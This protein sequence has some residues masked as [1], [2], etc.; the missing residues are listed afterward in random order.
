MRNLPDVQSFL[1]PVNTKLVTN[2]LH[3]VAKPMDLHTIQINIKQKKYK[4]RS[5]F[6]VDINQ[7][8]ENSRL[9]YGPN[10]F[11]SK[12]A[13]KLLEFCCN[14]MVQNDDKLML[15]EQAINPLLD[16]QNQKKLLLI[17]KSCLEMLKNMS[18]AFYFLHPVNEKLSKNYF[19][20]VKKPMDL[21]TIS[22]NITGK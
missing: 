3:I 17:L 18:E 22:N 20:I 6:L 2:Y 7:I 8:V 5:E 10:H 9:Y 12:V 21:Q 15:L 4:N 14:K 13:K 19:K 16:D 11:Y 1:S